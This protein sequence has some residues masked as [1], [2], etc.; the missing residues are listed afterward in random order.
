[1]HRNCFRFRSAQYKSPYCV[2]FQPLE[3]NFIPLFRL[4]CFIGWCIF[5]SFCLKRLGSLHQ[6]FH[7]CFTFFFHFFLA[8]PFCEVLFLVMDYFS[9]LQ[10][11]RYVQPDKNEQFMHSILIDYTRIKSI[12]IHKNPFETI[13]TGCDDDHQQWK[14]LFPIFRVFLGFFSVV[15]ANQWFFLHWI[16]FLEWKIRDFWNVF[17]SICLT[18]NLFHIFIIIRNTK[19]CR[20]TH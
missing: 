16:D 4:L 7:F 8:R 1:M 11:H 5:Y 10:N 20:W 13:L 19:Y 18:H 3:W 15:F 9:L 2:L 17:F 14:G 12:K 6:Y